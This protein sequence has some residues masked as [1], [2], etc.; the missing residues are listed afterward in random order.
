MTGE[1]D[2]D[3]EIYWSAYRN[4]FIAIMDNGQYI[5]YGESVDGLNWPAMQ[6][7][8]GK[9]PQTAVYGYA[10][11]VGMGSDPNILGDTFYSYY[12]AWPKG[13]SWQPA[14]LSRLTLTTAAT[15]KTI[16]PPEATAGSSGFTLTVTGDHFVKTSTVLWD[17][18]PRETTYVS[19]AELT[20]QILASDVATAG[21]AKVTVL[22]PAP[23]G[24]I[25]NAEPFNVSSPWVP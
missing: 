16:V 9:N 4:R 22:N 24:G 6:V 17:G 5:A 19:A 10:I 3:P 2:G 8:L 21:A 18:S 7:V 25:S 13:I 23:C 14:T 1:T 15:T 20:A 12:T 11:A